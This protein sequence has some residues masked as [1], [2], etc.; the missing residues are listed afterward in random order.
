LSGP[1]TSL[2]LPVV[3]YPAVVV[4]AGGLVTADGGDLPGLGVR[5]GVTNWSGGELEQVDHQLQGV[6]E[7]LAH[8]ADQ[9]VVD[10]EA[11]LLRVRGA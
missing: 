9:P 8:G 6:V 4:G 11:G 5:G 1:A 2:A 7:T 3:I 10:V